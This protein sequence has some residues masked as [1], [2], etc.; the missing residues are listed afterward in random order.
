MNLLA[1]QLGSCFCLFALSASSKGGKCLCNGQQR[2]LEMGR[3]NGGSGKSGCRNLP[4]SSAICVGASTADVNFA[5]TLVMKC[6]ECM[7][8][9]HTRRKRSGVGLEIW[10]LEE[11]ASWPSPASLPD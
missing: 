9:G 6:Y 4:P 11:A 5:V 8:S 10:L 2:L 3:L 1:P 7:F